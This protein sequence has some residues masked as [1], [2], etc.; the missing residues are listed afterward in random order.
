MGVCPVGFGV[1][2]IGSGGLS[3]NFEGLPC[4]IWGS[5]TG[6]RQCPIGG[7]RGLVTG[8]TRRE[9]S[10]GCC[11]DSCADD[12]Q[13]AAELLI[14]PSVAGIPVWG[15]FPGTALLS[16]STDNSQNSASLKSL[17]VSWDSSGNSLDFHLVPWRSAGPWKN[18]GHG[19]A[20]PEGRWAGSAT[21]VV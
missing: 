12:S 4:W 20:D 21:Q 1:C 19:Q 17:T 14:P 5:L 9:L 3:M 2:P 16:L 7:P 15:P 10:D 11:C 6:F 18:L 8:H 13:G